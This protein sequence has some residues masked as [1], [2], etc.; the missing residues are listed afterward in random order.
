MHERTKAKLNQSQK[1]LPFSGRLRMTLLARNG[2]LGVNLMSQYAKRVR[3]QRP[4]RQLHG[5]HHCSSSLHLRY[6]SRVQC[7]EGWCRTVLY[8]VQL[9]HQTRDHVGICNDLLVGTSET[10]STRD[11]SPRH[12]SPTETVG[13]KES[14]TFA[15]SC[16]ATI[17]FSRR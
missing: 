11:L 12:A 3:H 10:G 2:R 7:G 6:V 1:P 8:D 15:P 9:G 16:F 14:A 4:E 17:T 5:I 13:Q